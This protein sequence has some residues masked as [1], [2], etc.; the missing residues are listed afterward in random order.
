MRSPSTHTGVAWS[1]ARAADSG[2][3]ERMWRI[4]SMSAL[5]PSTTAS[6]LK[7]PRATCAEPTL[8][9]ATR[10]TRAGGDGI[11]VS[12]GEVARGLAES[13][14]GAARWFPRGRG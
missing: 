5:E 4:S 8:S 3:G 9:G 12:Q 14:P 7:A 11:G 1:L 13:T 2:P 10:A 6:R